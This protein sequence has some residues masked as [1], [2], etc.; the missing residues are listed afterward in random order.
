MAIEIYGFGV[1]LV[2]LLIEYLDVT[3]FNTHP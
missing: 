1:A 2:C 3:C